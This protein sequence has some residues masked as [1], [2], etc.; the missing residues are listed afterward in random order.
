MQS[1]QNTKIMIK[2]RHILYNTDKQVYMYVVSSDKANI[3]DGYREV[4]LGSDMEC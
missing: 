1:N 3:P 2:F 4:A